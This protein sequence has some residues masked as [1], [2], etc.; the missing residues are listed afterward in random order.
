LRNLKSIAKR[1]AADLLGNPPVFL[2]SHGVVKFLY[3]PFVRAVGYHDTPSRFADNLRHQMRWFARHFVNCGPVDLDR[4]LT[5]QGWPHDKPGLIISFD[6]GLRSNYQVAAPI[7]EEFGFTGWFMVPASVP[8][9]HIEEQRAFSRH[10]LIPFL[11]ES[12]SGRV[13]MDWQELSSLRDRGH[14][15][16]VHSLKHKRLGSYRTTNELKEEIQQSRDVF[17]EKL[18]AAPDTFA[19]V[20]GESH[21][22]SKQAFDLMFQ[23]GYRRVFSTNCFPITG[24]ETSMC[25]ERNHVDAAFTLNEVRLSIGGAYDLVY[26][27]KRRRIRELLGVSRR[28]EGRP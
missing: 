10:A 19:W 28:V 1:L 13:F 11:D 6:D 21:A 7:L 20:G 25:L 26:F 22:F 9:I 3:S 27:T 14:V 15:V 2:A 4:F 23:A 5:G 17:G 18:G 24:R 8:D 12:P 16:A